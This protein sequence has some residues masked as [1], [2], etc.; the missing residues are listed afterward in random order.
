MRMRARSVVWVLLAVPVLGM[1]LAVP[2]V[3]AAETCECY[4]A[5]DGKGATKYP[6]EDTKL[7]LDQCQKTC[8]DKGYSVATCAYDPSQK[9]QYNVMCFTPDE[10]NSQ[11]GILTATGSGTQTQ[12]GECKKGMYYCYPDPATRKEVTLQVAIGGLTVTGD[13]GKYI[14]YVYKWMLGAGTTISIVLLMVAG[15]RWSLGGTNAE[16]IGKAKKTI[17][18]AMV[19]LILLLS[20]YVIIYTVNPY[21]VRLQVPAFPMI[22]TVSLVGKESCGYLQGVWGSSAYLIKN[23][24]PLDSPHA[25]G[26]GDAYTLADATNGTQ[27]G[28]VAKVTHDPKGKRII[29][30]QTCTY[31][32]CPDAST[33]C[34]PYS[35]KGDCLSCLDFGYGKNPPREATETICDMFNTEE[36]I[37]PNEPV[38]QFSHSSILSTGIFKGITGIDLNEYIGKPFCLMARDEDFDN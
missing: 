37:D 30:D 33:R 9:P 11:K 3:E 7:S 13:L 17:T 16:Q 35:G 20:T 21:L 24:A 18:N 6:D 12:P 5:R 2:R 19:G 32:Y 26:I 23:G 15:L 28:S 8:T 29:D 14:S 31:D 22:K 10:C 34:F 38:C 25:P 36:V 4:C 27:C 1:A